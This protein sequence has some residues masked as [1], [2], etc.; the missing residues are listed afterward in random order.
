[1]LIKPGLADYRASD[2]L[3]WELLNSRCSEKSKVD[4]LDSARPD[5]SFSLLWNS[6][7][8]NK[9]LKS[10]IASKRVESG[11]RGSGE[12]TRAVADANGVV[13]SSYSLAVYRVPLQD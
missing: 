11:I 1:M 6:N 13:S 7:A 10:G 4:R 2:V 12:S 3:R 5:V 8:T 9:V